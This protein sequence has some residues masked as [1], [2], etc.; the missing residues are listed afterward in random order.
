M[1]IGAIL[2]QGETQRTSLIFVQILIERSAPKQKYSVTLGE[3]RN[4][5]INVDCTNSQAKD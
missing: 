4:L 2:V 1:G 5:K 3:I